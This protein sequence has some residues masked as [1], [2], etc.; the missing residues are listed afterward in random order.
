MNC[1]TQ[2]LNRTLVVKPNIY[3][4]NLCKFQFYAT[5]GLFVVFLPHCF[6]Q[7]VRDFYMIFSHLHQVYTLAKNALKGRFLRYIKNLCKIFT[8]SLTCA[9][10]Q[11]I[12]CLVIR[13]QFSRQN[14]GLLI[15]MSLVR[16]QLPE[17][18]FPRVSAD[19][20]FLAI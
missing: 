1:I 5:S 12:I 19:F 13:A 16:V 10:F 11:Y 7:T 3:F 4:L 2:G 6:V 18:R 20:C 8:K 14:N 17:P 15:R 9:D